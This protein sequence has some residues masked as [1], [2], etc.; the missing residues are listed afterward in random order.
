VFEVVKIAEALKRSS[1]WRFDRNFA[2]TLE[3][4]NASTKA[5][6]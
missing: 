2:S 6:T 5:D 4:F 3:H 1:G